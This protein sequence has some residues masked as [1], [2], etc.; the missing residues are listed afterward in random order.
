MESPDQD[1]WV[2][3]TGEY[4][5]NMLDEQDTV[6]LE[7]VIQHEPEIEK[8]IADWDNWFQPISDSLTPIEPPAKVLSAVLAN[9]PKQPRSSVAANGA[10]SE[11]QSSGVGKSS[12]G[13]V[14]DAANGTS[15]MAL[16]RKNQQQTDRWR[17]FA[18]LA[19][20]AC[21]LIGLYIGLAAA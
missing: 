11:S 18:G 1:W 5:L 14:S 2:V 3:H 6:V 17:G 20:V 8:L 7:R 9:L 4:V 19:V 15:M 21:L 12:S 10:A 16:L 13:S